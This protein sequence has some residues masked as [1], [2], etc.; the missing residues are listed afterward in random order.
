MKSATTTIL[1]VCCP[2]WC[3]ESWA[4]EPFVDES[5]ILAVSREDQA[6][7]L[8]TRLLKKEVC[9]PEVLTVLTTF[10]RVSREQY[11][12][13]HHQIAGARGTLTL[14]DGKTCA[15]EIE[16]GYAAQVKDDKGTVTYLLHPSLPARQARGRV[17]H[18]VEGRCSHRADALPGRFAA[19]QVHAVGR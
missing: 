6:N 14:K 12:T 9:L 10:P 18:L 5:A 17:H 3:P 4:G 16:P 8:K 7:A 2:L 19:R 15:W 1:L 11:L 13:Y